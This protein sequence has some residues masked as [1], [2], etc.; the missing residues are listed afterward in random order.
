RQ[1]PTSEFRRER[2]QPLPPEA[3]RSA[4][5][6]RLTVPPARGPRRR[7]GL[8]LMSVLSVLVLLASGTSWA[9]TGWM[10]GNLNRFDV[11]GGLSDEDRP[12]NETGGLTFLVIGSDNRDGT[13]REDQDDVS[14][15]SV[16]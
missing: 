3:P 6:A 8:L 5:S 12:E 10:S 13:S 1:E 14:A 16:E 2:A 7:T 9:I 15:G 11:F 4:R